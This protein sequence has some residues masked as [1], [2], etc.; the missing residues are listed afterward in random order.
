MD[1]DL[2]K[3]YGIKAEPV[4]IFKKEGISQP[5]KKGWKGVRHEI[6][7][8]IAEP[9]RHP[10][11]SAIDAAAGL[12]SE[13]YGLGKQALQ[14]PFDAIR[15]H[16]PRLTKNLAQGFENFV[17][18]PANIAGYLGKHGIGFPEDIGEKAHIKVN[19]FEMGEQQAGDVL[20]QGL[21][22]LAVLGPLGEAG[23]LNQLSRAGARG[24]SGASI[25]LTQNQNPIHTALLNAAIPA[26]IEKTPGFTNKA[27]AN[28]LSKD[29][30]IATQEAAQKYNKWFN[31]AREYGVNK[32]KRPNIMA[33]DIVTHSVPK[34]HE[35][36]V[37]FLNEPTLEHAHWAQSDLG[38]LKR[39]LEN[40]A[41]KQDLTSTQHNTLKN[42]IQAQNRIKQSMF[43]E[44]NMKA[45]PKM[46]E[47]YNQLSGDYAQNVVP[48]KSLQELSEYEQKKLKPN[49][50]I[51]S[52]LNNDEFMLG[53]GKNYPQIQINRALRSKPA[54]IIGGTLLGGSLGGLGFEGG[55]KLIQ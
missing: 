7:E 22:S 41:K 29:K 10:L 21:P 6:Y 20:A 24:L 48:L 49:K 44:K 43:N 34:H 32:I 16:V 18:M 30:K 55:R 37:K 3:E 12:G 39:H 27:I 36:L 13:T 9:L 15:G 23:Q 53:I 42:V 5:G 19:P 51:Q 8:S 52:L 33:G 4:D 46:Q 28:T 11:T 25:G 2:F 38:F 35:A 31:Q 50:L 1:R 54:K 17:N 26:A 45:N 47:Q 40:I 14:L